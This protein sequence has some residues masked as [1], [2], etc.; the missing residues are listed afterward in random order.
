LPAEVISPALARASVRAL[1]P[2]VTDATAADLALL[3]TEVV[4]NAVTHGSPNMGDEILLRILLDG[5]VR[6]EVVDAGPRLVPTR[7]VL[8]VDGAAGGWGMFLLDE[9]ADAW[10]IDAN[11]VRKMVWFELHPG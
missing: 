3:V 8:P 2:D 5:R 10:G 6:I 1:T 4:T 9:I 11:G 7:S